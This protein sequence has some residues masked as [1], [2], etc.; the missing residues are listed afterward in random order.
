VLLALFFL[1]HLEETFNVKL[2]MN[3]YEVTG[4]SVEE[5]SI[6]VNRILEA[7]HR[8]MQ[9]VLAGNTGQHIRLQFDVEGCSREQKQL[10][11]QLKASTV[12]QSATSLGRVERE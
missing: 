12:L 7:H 8:L 2:L 6:E 9:N 3:S 1:G 10:L 5:I 11:Q 4:A